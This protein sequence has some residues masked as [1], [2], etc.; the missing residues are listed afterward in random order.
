[1]SS[2]ETPAYELYA[3]LFFS[4]GFG[5]PLWGFPGSERPTR[6]G[7]VGRILR[8]E[9]YQ[10]FYTMQN[11]DK[12]KDQDQDQ[13]SDATV[14]LPEDFEPL[15]AG[16]LAVWEGTKIAEPILHSRGVEDVEMGTEAKAESDADPDSDAL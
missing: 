3:R 13:E 9:F 12:D 11:K 6:I 15:D 14:A 1:M 2:P 4:F 7:A 16:G 8:G 10:L 5:Y